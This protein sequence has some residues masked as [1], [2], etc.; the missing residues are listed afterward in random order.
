MNGLKRTS[1]TNNLSS[2]EI[3]KKPKLNQVNKS[4]TTTILGATSKPSTI[5][6][7][8][9]K[10]IKQPSTTLT[11][12]ATNKLV[13]KPNKSVNSNE[14]VTKNSEEIKEKPNNTQTNRKL[15][16][17]KPDLENKNNTKPLTTNGSAKPSTITEPAKASSS[18][19]K[20]ISLLEVPLVKPSKPITKPNPVKSIAK[21]VVDNKPDVSEVATPKISNKEHQN[22]VVSDAL[23]SFNDVDER[24][25]DVDDRTKHLQGQATFPSL[26]LNE[27]NALISESASKGSAKDFLANLLK[28]SQSS[29]SLANKKQTV[30]EIGESEPLSD[31]LLQDREN[32]LNELQRQLSISQ[33]NDAASMDKVVSKNT[34]DLLETIGTIL[35]MTKKKM[36]T[37]QQRSVSRN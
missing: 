4:P 19:R 14:N 34:Q 20:L 22:I 24:M 13:S 11:T 7:I 10:P 8:N 12:T 23:V 25:G 26:K 18:P 32:S 1:P 9:T 21:P 5:K 33:S 3:I 15:V 16:K 28:V 27:L 29:Q 37:E 17:N 2:G 35:E 31:K 6:T 36:I 30:M